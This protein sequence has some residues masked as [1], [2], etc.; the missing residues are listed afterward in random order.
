MIRNYMMRGRGESSRYARSRRFLGR[1]AVLRLRRE[2]R[3]SAQDDTFFHEKYPALAK[4]GLERGNRG[5]Y[6]VV[7]I[8]PAES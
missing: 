3:G 1:M 6:F 8:S 4:V 2:G 7:K 5:I